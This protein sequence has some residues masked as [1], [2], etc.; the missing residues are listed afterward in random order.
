MVLSTKPNNVPFIALTTT[1]TQKTKER[2]FE[3]L[4]F[5]SPKA[6]FESPNE[7]NVRYSVQKLA[8]SLFIIENFCCLVTGLL[9]KGKGSTRTII[10]CQTVKQC[11]QLYKMF[12]LHWNLVHQCMKEKEVPRID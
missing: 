1:A 4:E 12:E 6:I 8:N 7:V 5:G 2:I 3:L 10:Y 11:S 9:H